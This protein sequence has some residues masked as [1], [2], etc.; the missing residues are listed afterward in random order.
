ML[1]NGLT[2]TA[3]SELGIELVVGAGWFLAALA[4]FALFAEGGRKDGSIDLVE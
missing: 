3:L 4:G 2:T 1:A